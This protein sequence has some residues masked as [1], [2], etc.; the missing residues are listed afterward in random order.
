MRPAF[1]RGV[2]A[3]TDQL[4][5]LTGCAALAAEI[6]AIKRNLALIRATNADGLEA[7]EEKKR[8]ISNIEVEMLTDLKNDQTIK[9]RL[10]KAVS[11]L[12]GLKVA[13]G[14]LLSKIATAENAIAER[15]ERLPAMRSA[16]R[17]KLF[18]AA[19]EKLMP[20]L[21]AAVAKAR[22]ALIELIVLK[23]IEQRCS[24]GIVDINKVAAL[25]GVEYPVKEMAW[26]LYVQKT[27]VQP[28]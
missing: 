16:E 6:E 2:E 21:P 17:G 4:V 13:H 12:V 27:G 3:N 28:M 20:E 11:E 1:L 8:E 9:A 10:S 22:E 24:P 14:E 19:R 18:E 15:E 7:V 25:L 5:G 26:N 23:S